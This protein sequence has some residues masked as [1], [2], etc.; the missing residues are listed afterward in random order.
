M[1]PLE[2]GKVQHFTHIHRKQGQLVNPRVLV[3]RDKPDSNRFIHSVNNSNNSVGPLIT[4]HCALCSYNL[5]AHATTAKLVV[6]MATAM[7]LMTTPMLNRSSNN[8]SNN[9][10]SGSGTKM[11]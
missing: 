8:N 9:S 6:L 7:A 1:H 10:N 3:V 4:L 11:T 2:Q 5:S